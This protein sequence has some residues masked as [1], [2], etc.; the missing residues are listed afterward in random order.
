MKN[1]IASFLIALVAVV[2]VGALYAV[3]TFAEEE[4]DPAANSLRISPSG[5]RLSLVPGDVLVDNVDGCISSVSDS[6]SVQV[7][8]TGKKAFKYK[9]YFSPYVVSGSDNKLSFAEEDSTSHTQ[10]SRWLKVKNAD[11]EYVDEA[12]FTINPGETQTINYQVTIPEDIPGG[13]QYAV[14]WAQIVS[15][16]IGSSGI[17]TVGQVGSV[18][19]GSSATG[20]VRSAE[21]LDVNMTHFTFGGGVHAGAKVRNTGNDDFTIDYSYVVNN[22]FGGE[23]YR[24]EQSLAAYPETDYEID[25]NWEEPPLLGI[26]HVQFKINAAG[27][28]VVKSGVVIIIPIVVLI[29]MILLLTIIIVWIII[30]I[31]KRKERNARKLV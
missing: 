9:V 23:R 21:I 30:V 18:I 25:V 28:E 17:Q 1:K 15:N 3:P 20:T 10:I 5:T 8:N 11:G 19:S 22:F 7:Q 2:S 14:L 27:E 31:R 16:D 13:S 12:T 6:C 24:D 4:E 26:F 29:L